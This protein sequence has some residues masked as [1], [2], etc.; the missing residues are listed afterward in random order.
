MQGREASGP[1]AALSMAFPALLPDSFWQPGQVS[2]E[3]IQTPEKPEKSLRRAKVGRTL[4]KIQTHL[5]RKEPGQ[6]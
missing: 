2:A 3:D 4:L 5:I 1:R 6:F